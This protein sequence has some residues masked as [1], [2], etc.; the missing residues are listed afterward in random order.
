MNI[1]GPTN[2]HNYGR[3][4]VAHSVERARSTTNRTF[5]GLGETT[6]PDDQS[7][8]LLETA[9]LFVRLRDQPEI[10][11]GVLPPIASKVQS[12]AYNTPESAQRLADAILQQAELD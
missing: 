9:S 10:R 6:A 7:L 5:T 11:E 1:H 3:T 8:P 4:D 2:G 12:G